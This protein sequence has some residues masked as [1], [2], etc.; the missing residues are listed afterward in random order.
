MKTRDVIRGIGLILVLAVF[1]MG[2]GSSPASAEEKTVRIFSVEEGRFVERG[3]V[4][5]GEGEW[6]ELLNPEQFKILRKKGTERAFTGKYW[7]HKEEGV[8]RCAGCGTDLFASDTKFK[9]GTGWPSFWE[10]VAEE[11]IVTE[12]DYSLFGIKR[13]EILCALCG[14]HLGHVF[15]DGPPPTGLR[16]CINSASLVFAA[17]IGSESENK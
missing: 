1:A 7:D 14:G 11:N 13:V 16:Y 12:D 3:K 15:D 4:V 10:P 6:R 5:R 9:S 2:T 17:G 8:Y